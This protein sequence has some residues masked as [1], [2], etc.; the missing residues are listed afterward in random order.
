MKKI[1]MIV[2]VEMD[3]VL[4]RYGKAGREE[5]AGG[6]EIS[7]YEMEG[8]TL[9]VLN[10]GIGELAAAAAAQLLI[11]RYQVDLIVN[12]G[13]VGA[14]TQELSGA[15]TCIVEKLVHYNF[16]LSGIDPLAPG[17]Y[18]G[19]EDVYIQVSPELVEHAMRVCPQLKKV[20][21]ASG[22]KFVGD[23][24]EKKALHDKYKAHIC[25]M[26]AAGIVLTCARNKLPCLC[27]KT[28][29]DGLDGGA[30]EYYSQL[31]KSSQ[32]CLEVTEKII[33]NL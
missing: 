7:C 2:A 25:E 13:V 10:S 20:I 22:D 18:P 16:D 28:V 5:L 26:E 8:Y 31:S 4:S 21:C 17:Q 27:I 6:F 24:Q 19:Y 3:S 15:H 12:F 23:P 32:L 33:E 1:G 11:D 9:H 29:A 30:E 14:L